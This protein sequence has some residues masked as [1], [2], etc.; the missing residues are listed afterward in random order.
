MRVDIYIQNAACLL[1]LVLLCWPAFSDLV[2]VYRRR[3]DR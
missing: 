1:T 3:G 2:P